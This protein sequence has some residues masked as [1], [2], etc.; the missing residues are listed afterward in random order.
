MNKSTITLIVLA[1]ALSGL[2]LFA[3][4]ALQANAPGVQLRAATE[5]EEVEGDLQAAIEQYPKSINDNGENRPVA[6]RALLRLA[7]CYE[8]LGRDEAQ[9]TY[10]RLIQ[11]Y[12]DQPEVVVE[13]RTRLALLAR[14]SS[15]TTS[16]PKFRRL[17]IPA[18]HPLPG[19]ATVRA[20]L[21]QDP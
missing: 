8:K 11:D 20:S 7:G 4:S 18:A 17:V 2:F 3:G 15:E 12:A 5:K 21:S 9:K 10:E 6:A 1:I 19:L 16:T 13:A 14:I